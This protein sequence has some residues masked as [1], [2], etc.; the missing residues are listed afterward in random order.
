MGNQNCAVR[1]RSLKTEKDEEA[2]DSF[3]LSS[4]DTNIVSANVIP[5][6]KTDKVWVTMKL[7]EEPNNN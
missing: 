1:R 6:P 3:L 7:E 2:L 5:Q 4:A